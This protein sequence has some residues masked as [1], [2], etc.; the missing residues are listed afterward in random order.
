MVRYGF[1]GAGQAVRLVFLQGVLAGR[2]SRLYVNVAAAQ[3][4]AG[5]GPGSAAAPVEVSG[6]RVGGAAVMVGDGAITL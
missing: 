5:S 4:A 3:A 2:P 6:V 1:A